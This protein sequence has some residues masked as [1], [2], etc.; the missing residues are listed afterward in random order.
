M[1]VCVCVLCILYFHIFIIFVCAFMPVTV[2]PY[3]FLLLMLRTALLPPRCFVCCKFYYVIVLSMNDIT[4]IP[5]CVCARV[6][7]VRI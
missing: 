7:Y 6:F 5:R 2:V 3:S 1:C 4:V